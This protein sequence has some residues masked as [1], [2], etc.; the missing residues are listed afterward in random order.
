MRI[1][2]I[3]FLVFVIF[4]CKRKQKGCWNLLRVCCW[5][6]CFSKSKVTHVQHKMYK[7]WARCQCEQNDFWKANGAR[8]KKRQIKMGWKMSAFF[9]D[10]IYKLFIGWKTKPLKNWRHK[11]T[12]YYVERIKTTST[13]LE[14]RIEYGIPNE[15]E[16]RERKP[17]DYSTERINTWA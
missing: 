4:G 12:D 16:K 8:N 3:F 7:S 9:G 13:S 11:I 17:D 14:S 5:L 6:F 15:M 10:Y 1:S 2:N